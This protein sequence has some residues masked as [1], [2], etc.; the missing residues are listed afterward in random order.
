TFF[1]S[2]VDPPFSGKNASGSVCAHSARSCQVSSASS[3]SCPARSSR[4]SSARASSSTRSASMAT[5]PSTAVSTTEG[6]SALKYT[7][8]V[9]VRQAGPARR[10][11]CRTVITPPTPDSEGSV[12]ASSTPAQV[13]PLT[14]EHGA[15]APAPEPAP[16]STS[17]VLQVLPVTGLGEV[18]AG[19]DLA[20]LLAAALAPLS[21]REG[22]GLCGSTK[23]VS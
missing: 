10:L 17:A 18:R 2:R 7:G 1:A 6:P 19:D 16:P 14:P 13:T 11:A 4:V 22:D 12:S 9:M 20:T 3:V 21:P 15:P 23:L 8:V 5:T